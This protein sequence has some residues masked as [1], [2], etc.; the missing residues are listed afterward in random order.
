M[1]PEDGP[2]SLQVVM[3]DNARTDVLA[4]EHGR[5][6]LNRIRCGAC[7][8]APDVSAN[9]RTC[10]RQRV[11]R[12]YWCD[13]D[14]IT[15]SMKHASSLPFASSLCGACYEVCPVKISIPEVSV[16]LRHRVVE[17]ET[18]G[19][20][21]L[22]QPE[23][24]AMR[25]AGAVFRSERR[26]RAAQRLGRIVERPLKRIGGAGERWISLLPGLLG[27]WTSVR[28]LRAMPQESFREWWDKRERNGTALNRS[29]HHG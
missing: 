6:T 11:G 9:G 2:R 25:V 17:R 27:G 24:I 8:N 7:Q 19:V 29:E 18:T 3:L 22:T 23:A 4:D 28:D 26:F 13:S 10:L 12:T 5:E 14:T 15:A 20:G 16:H 21:M 1:D